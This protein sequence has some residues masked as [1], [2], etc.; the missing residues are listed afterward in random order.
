[1]VMN[2]RKKVVMI[3]AGAVGTAYAYSMAQHALADEFIIINHT[4]KKAVG[5]ALDLEDAVAAFETPVHMV[6]GDYADCAEADLVVI[7]AGVPQKP[8]ETR[9]QLVNKNLAVIKDITKNVVESG[10]QGIFLVAGNPVDI[11][12]NAV[13]E[14][15][16]FPANRVLSSGTSLDS[17]R[18]RIALAKLFNVSSRSIEAYVMAEHGDSEF[19]AFSTA[20]IG[21][22]PLL[23]FA[24]DRGYTLDELKEIEDNVRH[25][26]YSI[27]EGKGATYY[28]VAS[29]LVRI[30]EAILRNTN[31]VMPIGAYMTGEYG[32]H[33]V[34]LGTPAIINA[35]GI[36]RI[37][38]MPL[39]EDEQAAMANSAK[40]LQDIQDNAR[41]EGFLP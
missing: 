23:E 1:M 14:F 4:K 31:A 12:T 28:G 29:A 16:G 9:L 40:T 10:F 2:H 36:A 25:K 34:Y 17:Y 8:G 32:Q 7:T 26:A 35:N 37:I 13:R 21:G 22:K 33:G 6:P 20:T 30:T 19:A 39:N 3:G 24:K 11:L 27:I 15:S 38:E 41:K 18:L 5:N